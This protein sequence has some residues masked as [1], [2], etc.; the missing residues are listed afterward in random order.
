MMLLGHNFHR[1]L[2]W[3]HVVKRSRIRL[4]LT[5]QRNPKLNNVAPYIT[6]RCLFLSA[7]SVK[8]RALD[9]GVSI[10]GLGNSCLLYNAS[11]ASE[12]WKSKGSTTL[13]AQDVGYFTLQIG[14]NLGVEYALLTTTVIVNVTIKAFQYLCIAILY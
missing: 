1:S 5:F 11:N 6:Q 13:L 14:N 8:K 2:I 3:N 12:C 10:R 9:F 7:Q 4:D